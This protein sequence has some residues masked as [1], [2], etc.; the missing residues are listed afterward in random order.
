VNH[1]LEV[2]WAVSSFWYVCVCSGWQETLLTSIF[3]CSPRLPIYE[4]N[5]LLG[6]RKRFGLSSRMNIRE[7][8][9]NTSEIQQGVMGPRPPG[10]LLFWRSWSEQ[11][12]LQ[13]GFEKWVTRY[14]GGVGP[15]QNGR[16]DYLQ[17][18][19]Q[20]Y[21]STGIPGK[22][23]P[24]MVH[25]HRLALYQRTARDEAALRREQL[26]SNHRKNQATGKD[27]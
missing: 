26:M 4:K 25:L 18:K 15:H 10:R 2:V 1:F 19:S 11:S 13:S 22:F 9:T 23:G 14:Y 6:Y 8:S 21:R 27:G 5:S 24:T 20:R 17:L 7:E 16:R 12:G 3:F